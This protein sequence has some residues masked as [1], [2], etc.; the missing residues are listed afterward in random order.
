MLNFD[1][2]VEQG[3]SCL[4]DIGEGIDSSYKYLYAEDASWYVEVDRDKEQVSLGFH[5]NIDASR[6][7]K[8]SAILAKLAAVTGVNLIIDEC[9]AYL[10]DL[11]LEESM[12]R[13]YGLDAYAQTGR[14]QF[15]HFMD[16]AA[17]EIQGGVHISI[18]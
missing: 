11:D 17:N 6:A 9:H 2:F 10:I 4:Q 7:A 3:L 13:L 8:I 12:I 5:I 1:L 14:D 16:S 18:G 15:E